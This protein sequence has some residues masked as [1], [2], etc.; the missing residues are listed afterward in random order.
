MRATLGGSG[1]QILSKWLRKTERQAIL[2][3]DQLTRNGIVLGREADDERVTA[4]RVQNLPMGNILTSQRCVGSQTAPAQRVTRLLVEKSPKMNSDGQSQNHSYLGKISCSNG[5]LQIGGWPK[6]TSD[7][8][9][10]RDARGSRSSE[11]ESWGALG[12]NCLARRVFSAA[13]ALGLT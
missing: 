3:L 10:R 6:A 13:D 2:G 1:G 11:G 5:P 8:K 9:L 4:T 12:A 7:N